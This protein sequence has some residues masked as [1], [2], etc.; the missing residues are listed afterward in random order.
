MKPKINFEL[1]TAEVYDR[2]SILE[3]KKAHCKD[4]AIS[5]SLAEQCLDI[6]NLLNIE[7]GYDNA[8]QVYL[9]SEYKKLYLANYEI[10]ELIDKLKS[11]DISPKD[12]DSKNYLRYSAKKALQ[13]KFFGELE[14][15][16]LGY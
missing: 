12:V 14:E 2:L 5:Q 16:K 6:M 1:D 3:V 15:I 11:E 4:V 7:L 13:E 10:F 8:R 9:S